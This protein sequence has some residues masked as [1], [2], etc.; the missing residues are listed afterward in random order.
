MRQGAEEMIEIQIKADQ[1]LEIPIEAKVSL[2]LSNKSN[3]ETVA[4]LAT[5]GGTTKSKEEEWGWFLQWIAHL[6][7]EFW[8]KELCFIPL[9]T[10]NLYKIMLEVILVRCIWLMEKPWMLWVWEMSRFYCLM[11]LYGYY[12]RFDIFLTWRGIWFM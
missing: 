4:R 3:V 9:H 8:I 1:N 12:R 11:G 6:M 2:D 7:I 5:L 10:N